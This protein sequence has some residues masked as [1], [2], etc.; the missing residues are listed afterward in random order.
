MTK[1]LEKSGI[2]FSLIK[3]KKC[4]P[5]KLIS[6]FTES[7]LEDLKLLGMITGIL[8][9]LVW[10]SLEFAFQFY[11]HPEYVISYKKRPFSNFRLEVKYLIY[12]AFGV[13]SYLI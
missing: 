8:E 11:R 3:K 2:V 4:S 10:E 13:N 5:C 1:D 7:Q 12:Q 6:Y 9:N